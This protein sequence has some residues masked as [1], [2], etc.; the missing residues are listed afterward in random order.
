MGFF[1]FDMIIDAVK[2]KFTLKIGTNFLV[3]TAVISAFLIL[4]SANTVNVLYKRSKARSYGYIGH[5][6]DKILEY[7]DLS[8]MYKINPEIKNLP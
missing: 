1:V 6:K 4:F 5:Y 3:Y 2:N 8:V 7:N